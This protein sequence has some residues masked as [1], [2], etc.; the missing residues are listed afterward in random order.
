[1][2]DAEL[3][4]EANLSATASGLFASRPAGMFWLEGSEAAAGGLG[5]WTVRWSLKKS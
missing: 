3:L 2:N 1:L 5:P 4:L